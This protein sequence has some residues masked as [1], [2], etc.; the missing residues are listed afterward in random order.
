MT[1]LTLQVMAVQPGELHDSNSESEWNNW[2][3]ESF[4][5][6]WGW[7]EMSH[8]L[9]LSKKERK[10]DLNDGRIYNPV[11]CK[12]SHASEAF[13]NLIPSPHPTFQITSKSAFLL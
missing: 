2:W 11:L 6:G 10:S 1:G 5:L 4:A 8:F 12:V 9:E 3:P 13:V 7:G